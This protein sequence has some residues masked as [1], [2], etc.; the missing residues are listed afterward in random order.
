VT[1]AFVTLE[2]KAAPSAAAAAA[3]AGAGL[4][5]AIQQPTAPKSRAA[6]KALLPFAFALQTRAHAHR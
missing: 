3:A 5:L 4:S 1:I 2:L 6:T